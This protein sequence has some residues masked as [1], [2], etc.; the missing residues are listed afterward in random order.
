MVS[1]ALGAAVSRLTCYIDY[2]YR[3]T[4]FGDEI[5]GI[6]MIDPETGKHLEDLT[7]AAIFPAKSLHRS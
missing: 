3:I 2:G 4:F 5:E 7:H 6:E 1:S